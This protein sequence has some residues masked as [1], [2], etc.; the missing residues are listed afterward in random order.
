V[1][2]HDPQA[3]V[4]AIALPVRMARELLADGHQRTEQVGLED[5]VAPLEHHRHAFQ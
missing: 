5:R 4:G 3:H 2:G 1:L